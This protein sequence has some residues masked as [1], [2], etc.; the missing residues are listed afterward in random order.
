LNGVTWP[1]GLLYLLRQSQ[2]LC[3][4]CLFL[5]QYQIATGQQ[6][7]PE[8]QAQRPQLRRIAHHDNNFEQRQQ[9][10]ECPGQPQIGANGSAQLCLMR[11]G[12]FESGFDIKPD[13]AHT[14]PLNP[15]CAVTGMTRFH[16]EMLCQHPPAFI[17]RDG[18]HH[19]KRFHW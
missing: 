3:A 10:Q 11:V 2:A 9:C 6:Q 8:S 4:E 13:S 12:G 15:P 1:D 5:A 16:A 14:A 19:R 17:E 18:E 7:R